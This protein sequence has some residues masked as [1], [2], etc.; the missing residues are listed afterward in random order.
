LQR[1]RLI[2]LLL[3][4]RLLGRLVTGLAVVQRVLARLVG[5]GGA[6]PEA[7]ASESSRMP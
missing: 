1:R 4:P 6:T 2:E 7:N 3:L 5:L